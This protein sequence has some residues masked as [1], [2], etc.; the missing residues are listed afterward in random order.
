MGVAAKS[1][2]RYADVRVEPEFFSDYDNAPPQAQ[3]AV[4]KLLKT[5]GCTGRFPNGANIHRAAATENLWIGYVTRNGQHWRVL[6]SIHGSDI[7][8]ERLLSHDRMDQWL[9]YVLRT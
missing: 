5:I 9:K 7:V 3:K 4:D 2:G 8:F 6:F 1:N